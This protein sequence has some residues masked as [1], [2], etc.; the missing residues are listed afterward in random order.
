MAFVI[1]FLEVVN[2]EECSFTSPANKSLQE[3]KTVCFVLS[4]M[5]KNNGSITWI[6]QIVV[7]ERG[8]NLFIVYIV[9]YRS[10]HLVV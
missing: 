2:K 9:I 1:I 10:I 5:Q 4:I 3:K 7:P 6:Y 8:N